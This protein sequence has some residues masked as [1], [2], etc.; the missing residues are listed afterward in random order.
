MD[1]W[2]GKNIQQVDDFDNWGI[3][4]DYGSNAKDPQGGNDTGGS[5]TAVVLLVMEV[6]SRP[7]YGKQPCFDN[8]TDETMIFGDVT[9]EFTDNEGNL[10]EGEDIDPER[11]T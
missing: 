11:R 3:K 7:I 4:K 1:C 8:T 6:S 10:T 2:S 5:A 9:C